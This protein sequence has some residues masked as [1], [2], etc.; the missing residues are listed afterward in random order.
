MGRLGLYY[1]FYTLLYIV[2]YLSGLCTVQPMTFAIYSNCQNLS[3]FP[4]FSL[5]FKALYFKRIQK[6]GKVV[7]D[8]YKSKKD[9]MLALLLL[10]F[11]SVSIL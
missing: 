4:P 6:G 2:K 11:T 3:F 7:V 9:K 1:Q 8:L 5:H 10:F